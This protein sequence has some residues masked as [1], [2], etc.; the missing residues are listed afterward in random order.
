M[1]K[2]RKNSYVV[3]LVTCGS[4]RDATRIARAVVSRKLAA[5]VNM[6]GTPVHSVY[7][8]KGKV[9]EAREVLLV[10]KSSRV[11]LA[12]LRR[13]VERLHTYD[14]P[15]FLV[16]PVM[17]GSTRYLAWLADALRASD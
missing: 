12:A 9:K 16:V 3:V 11:R 1:A 17:T 5:C 7:R 2:S 8:W 15:E 14:V 13:E 6:L 10:I 4:R